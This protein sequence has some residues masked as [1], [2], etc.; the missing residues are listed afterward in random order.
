MENPSNG[1]VF[2][3][4]QLIQIRD[5]TNGISA[6]M[7]VKQL[8]YSIDVSGGT[9]TAFTCVDKNAYSLDLSEPDFKVNTYE[10]VGFD[11]GIG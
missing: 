10:D 5:S 4:N 2:D 6:Q 1:K 3:I 9:S 11:G 8:V 7:L